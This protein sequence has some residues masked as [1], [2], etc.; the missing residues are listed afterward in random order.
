MDNYVVKKIILMIK[1]ERL[2]RKFYDDGQLYIKV[3][4]INNKKKGLYKKFYDDGQLEY[5][6]N[7]INDVPQ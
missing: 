7:Y 1:R 5:E 3:N 4:Y 2:Y 6:V